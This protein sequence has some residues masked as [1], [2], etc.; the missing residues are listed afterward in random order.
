VIKDAIGSKMQ[1]NEE[2]ELE[3][4]LRSKE[5]SPKRNIN[6]KLKAKR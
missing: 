6:R 1:R 3:S 5:I 2:R 4:K